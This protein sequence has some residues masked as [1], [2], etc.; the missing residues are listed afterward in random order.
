MVHRFRLTSQQRSTGA[1]Q[2]HGC[3][4][5]SKGPGNSSTRHGWHSVDSPGNLT[6]LL[7]S[8]RHHADLCGRGMNPNEACALALRA[9]AGQGGSLQQGAVPW[10]ALLDRSAVLMRCMHACMLLG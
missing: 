7:L 1:G 2:A 4:G 9:A 10:T 3:S 5:I 6:A 8:C